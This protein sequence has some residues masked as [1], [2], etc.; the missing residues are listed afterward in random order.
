MSGCADCLVAY[1]YAD[2]WGGLIARSH[3]VETIDDAARAARNRLRTKTGFVSDALREAL[4]SRN[5]ET[6]LKVSGVTCFD[7]C[8]H[9]GHA[10]NWPAITQ[11]YRQL[12]R[13]RRQ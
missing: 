10:V 13:R 12:A 8:P 6:L 4:R 2:D 1:G 7:Y 3:I 11:D 5:V 9:C